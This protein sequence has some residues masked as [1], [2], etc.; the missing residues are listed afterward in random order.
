MAGVQ[1]SAQTT[2]RWL[3]A[4]RTGVLRSIAVFDAPNKFGIYLTFFTS[5]YNRRFA[6]SMPLLREIKN[7]DEQVKMDRIRYR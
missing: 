1:L 5:T 3:P 7:E 6:V 2:A 4:V